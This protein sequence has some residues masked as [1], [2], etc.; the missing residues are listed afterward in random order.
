MNSFEIRINGTDALMSKLNKLQN[1]TKSQQF[2][3]CL[4]DAGQAY[5]ILA[6]RDAPR[7]THM[8]AKS[9]HHRVEG[10]GTPT[11]KVRIGSAGPASRYA[12]YVENGTKASVRTPRL[13]R[14]MFWYSAGPGGKTIKV[15]YGLGKTGYTSN[16]RRVVRHPGTP[17][18][19]H[20]L[21]HLPTIRAALLRQ[22]TRV[23]NEE[24]SSAGQ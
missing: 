17:A 24:L 5:V 8:L 10:F 20:F 9:Y 13:A 7:D 22:M 23:L 2:R 16:F 1:F 12:W 19:P 21:K 6:H 15:P 4:E 11:V 18:I 3:A 14:L